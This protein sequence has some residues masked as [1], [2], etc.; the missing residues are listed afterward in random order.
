MISVSRYPYRA[1]SGAVVSLLFYLFAGVAAAAENSAAPAAA[2]Q[3]QASQ[4]LFL[5]L[6]PVLKHPRCS[7]CHIVGDM[8]KTGDEQKPHKPRKVR[9]TCAKCHGYKNS[10]R[11]PGA[12]DWR[13]PP[14]AMGWDERSP[15]EICHNL[16]N[17]ATNGNRTPQDLA[18]HV[19][20]SPNVL[21]AW[22]PGGQLSVPPLPFA[23][24]KAVF[25]RWVDSGAHCPDE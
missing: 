22:H 7:N 24:F 20:S 13:A 14:A 18:Y 1:L 19:T 12:V 15:A 5:Q 25:A 11:A 17:P 3:M 23:E 9:G 10:P 16:T 6:A 4:A 8:H 21:W 2:G